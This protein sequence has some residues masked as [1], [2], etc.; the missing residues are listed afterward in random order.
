M[1]LQTTGRTTARARHQ[2]RLSRYR[3]TQMRAAGRRTK[4]TGMDGTGR[5]PAAET[6]SAHEQPETVRKIPARQVCRIN[7]LPGIQTQGQENRN[8]PA[9]DETAECDARQ[10]PEESIEMNKSILALIF[11]GSIGYVIW[12]VLDDWKQQDRK[13]GNAGEG[14]DF[15]F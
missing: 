11:L 13:N 15:M 4:I 6:L 7:Q 14:N 5:R 2:A 3:Q 1:V 12:A 8:I 9:P 10:Q